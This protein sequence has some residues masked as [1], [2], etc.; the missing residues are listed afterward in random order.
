MPPKQFFS[1]VLLLVALILGNANARQLRGFPTGQQHK[2]E[3]GRTGRRLGST[4]DK[5]TSRTTMVFDPALGGYVMAGSTRPPNTPTAPPTTNN[6]QNNIGSSSGTGNTVNTVTGGG[7]SV[8][9]NTNTGANL[10]PINVVRP[11]TGPPNGNVVYNPVCTRVVQN[12]S[13]CWSGEVAIKNF[14]DGTIFCVTPLTGEEAD[15][16]I[17][18]RP[19]R[20]VGQMNSSRTNPDMP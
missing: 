2:N 8:W 4:D 14:A 9:T 3:D 12:A 7:S 15:P 1:A 10:E 17:C 11:S 6:N 18:Y 19:G 20:Q 13:Q 16:R 5:K